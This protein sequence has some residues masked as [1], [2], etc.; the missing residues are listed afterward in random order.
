MSERV[1]EACDA[2]RDDT[3]LWKG[4][5]REEGLAGWLVGRG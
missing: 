5:K 4:E 1:G 2:W 3:P